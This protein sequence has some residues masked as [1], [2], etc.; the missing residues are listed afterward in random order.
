MDLGQ[1]GGG[2]LELHPVE[3]VEPHQLDQRS[4]LRLRLPELERAAV[5]TQAPGERR[6]VEHQRRVGKHQLR[7]IHHHVSRSLH[8]P[9]HRGSAERLGG[10]VFLSLAPQ[11]GTVVVERDATR[12]PITNARQFASPLVPISYT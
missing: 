10:P 12:V 3:A 7:E 1:G 5:T 11:D 8:R 6:Q 4:D 9:G 2:G